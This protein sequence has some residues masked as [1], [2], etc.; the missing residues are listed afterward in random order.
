M[1]RTCFPAWGNRF[2]PY[3][4]PLFRPVLS[5]LAPCFLLLPG[6][7]TWAQKRLLR[8]PWRGRN[9]LA[10]AVKSKTWSQEGQGSSPGFG[11]FW[12]WGQDSPRVHFRDS[13]FICK[14]RWKCPPHKSR[15][16]KHTP[17]YSSTA[18]SFPQVHICS[19][20]SICLMSLFPSF[21]LHDDQ[22]GFKPWS[23]LVTETVFYFMV[24]FNFFK[25]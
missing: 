22:F 6:I 2:R 23:F 12:G 16:W 3:R 15:W 17:L 10:K 5:E 7:R 14:M 18:S 9:Q 19:L 8:G 1:S 24:I 13:H 25:C 20:I 21:Y 11:I 4:S